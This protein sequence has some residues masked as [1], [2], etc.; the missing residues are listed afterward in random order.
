MMKAIISNNNTLVGSISN[1][2]SIIGEVSSEGSLTGELN[3]KYKEVSA[4]ASYEDLNNLPSIN[5]VTLMGNKT[6]SQLKIQDEM[7]SLTNVEIA[8]I[9]GLQMKGRKL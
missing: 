7:Q 5:G 2:G 1:S 4:N 3:E 9:F 8:N 6:S